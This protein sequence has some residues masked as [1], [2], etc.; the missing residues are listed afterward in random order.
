M[1]A[2]DTARLIASLELQDKGFSKGIQNATGS[3]G[4]LESRMGRIGGIASRGVQTAGQNIARLGAIA[5]GVIATQV[6]AGIRSLEELDRVTNATAGVITSTGGAAGVT[7]KQVRDLATSLE[8]VT[9]ADD[10]VIQ[11]GANLLLTFTNIGKETFPQATKAMV[12]LGI[13]MAQGD[14]ANADFKS[15]AIQ[16]GKALNDP[17]RGITALRRVGVSFTKQQEDQIKTL[18]KAGK[19]VDAQRLILAEL[20]K[21]FGKAG[22]AAGKGFGA[23]IRRVQDAIEDAQQALATGFLPLIRKVADVLS[24][25]L[26]KPETIAAIKSFGESLAGGVDRLIG[27]AQ[28]LPWAQIGD[29]LKLAGQGAKAV[30]DAFTALPSWIQTAVLT[31]WGLNKLTGGAVFD[32]TAELGKGVFGQFFARGSP[33]N[34]MFVVPVGGSLGGGA[35]SVVAGGG[36]LGALKTLLKVAIPAALIATVVHEVFGKDI[37]NAIAQFAKTPIQRD[38]NGNAVPFRIGN[39]RT[40][41]TPTT[42]DTAAMA[43]VIAKTFGEHGS[44]GSAALRAFRGSAE[45]AIAGFADRI[46]YLA[47]AQ[48]AGAGSEKYLALVQRDIDALKTILP[49]ATGNQ[50][51]IITGE[52]KVLEGILRDKKF[53]PTSPELI[54][55]VRTSSDRTNQ[56]LEDN[57]AATTRAGDRT[58]D[59]IERLR[60]ERKQP[61]NVSVSLTNQVLVSSRDV[62]K[63][64]ITS[65]KLGYVAS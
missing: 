20:E 7:A 18:V 23:D 44:F 48:G 41:L 10:K 25:E 49:T 36:I 22:E 64:T 21:E 55:A 57:R 54:D 8:N 65:S 60:A 34:P 11:S 47:G 9:T 19:T 52:I 32:I 59:A 46:K 3:L 29:S 50:G 63:A 16:I 4:K 31:G 62:V 37:E 43:T 27:V 61:V 12:D 53:E 33:A 6:Y 30:F 13:A 51:A 17:I 15:S 42:T 45:G 26:A 40:G 38:E 1:A 39:R 24:R 28:R 5:A 2:A 58:Y 14:V 35:P 56:H